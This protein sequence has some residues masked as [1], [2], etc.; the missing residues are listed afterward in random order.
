M[1]DWL[2]GACK[3]PETEGDLTFGPTDLKPIKFEGPTELP[4]MPGT[5]GLVSG[6]IT[7]ITPDKWREFYIWCWKN[8]SGKCPIQQPPEYKDL[9]NG[10]THRKMLYQ[11]TGILRWITSVSVE[12]HETLNEAKEDT[13]ILCNYQDDNLT[14][15]SRRRTI[16]IHKDPEFRVSVTFEKF[17]ARDA[18]NTPS[19]ILQHVL[20]ASGKS[21]LKINRG[22]PSPIEKGKMSALTDPLEEG[23]TIEKVYEQ[24]KQHLISKRDKGFLVHDDG[25]FESELK[26]GLITNS[27]M[28]TR[29]YQPKDGIVEVFQI[30][31]NGEHIST[32][33]LRISAGPPTVAEAWT[34]EPQEVDYAKMGSNEEDRTNYMLRKNF[35]EW[36]GRY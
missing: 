36:T 28:K 1:M 7:E 10:T 24:V 20:D 5:Q 21:G 22:Q 2:F 29:W 27:G 15:M 4:G 25:N 33:F 35:Q 30:L 12:L 3:A 17:P 18:N 14:E 6:P 31:P 8:Y 23:I 11:A 34:V 9:G 16:R 26:D 32:S 13:V 19:M